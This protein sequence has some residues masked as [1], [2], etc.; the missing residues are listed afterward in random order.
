MLPILD[1]T[2][3]GHA[4]WLDALDVACRD[5]GC[6]QLRCHGLGDDLCRSVLADMQRFFA[7]PYR[8]KLDIERTADNPW[9]FYDR[10]LTKNARDWKQIFDV[11]PYAAAGPFAGAR[12]RW[13]EAL[14]GF[15]ETVEAYYA[16]S[17][18]LALILLG[19]I[20]ECLGVSR[21]TLEQEFGKGH[22]SFLR[23]NYYP[24]CA[25]ADQHLGISHHTDAGA[26]TVLL[27]DEQPGLQFLRG[28]DWHTVQAEPGALIINIG[29]IVQVWSNDRY[30]APLHR[31]L[32]NPGDSRFSAPFFLNPGYDTV[33]APLPGALQGGAPRYRPINWGEFRAG[34]A[35]G[36]YADLGAEVQISDFRT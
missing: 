7:L 28:D 32:A 21:G 9:G 6:F 29:D 17:E 12:P 35:A 20:G 34:R 36:D 2:Q 24:P 23:L 30:R 1:L 5:W 26:L 13:P 27:P 16:A 3:R 10:E 22:S 18:A 31:V 11:G 4:G 8:D 15:R 33:Y 19:D 25:Q 14:P